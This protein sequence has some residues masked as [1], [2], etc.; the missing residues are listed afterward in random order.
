MHYLVKFR[1][2]AN[3]FK[4]RTENHCVYFMPK[5]RSEKKYFIPYFLYFGINTG[6]YE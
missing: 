1:V 3:I 5:T 2:T 6:S 4:F